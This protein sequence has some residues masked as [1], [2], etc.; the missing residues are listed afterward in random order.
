MPK[1]FNL[2]GRDPILSD[3]R[4]PLGGSQKQSLE[5]KLVYEKYKLYCESRCDV[6]SVILE[7]AQKCIQ[8][9]KNKSRQLKGESNL[10]FK[11]INHFISYHVSEYVIADQ[12]SSG[13]KTQKYRSQIARSLIVEGWIQEALKFVEKAKLTA[14]ENLELMF[15]YEMEILNYDRELNNQERYR[16]FTALLAKMLR[17]IEQQD[18]EE[19]EGEAPKKPLEI[20]GFLIG[21]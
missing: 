1:Y 6:D 17:V 16:R 5:Q 2:I 10:M 4:D 15:Q 8:Q 19:Q 21:P 12:E 20:T 14:N 18:L 11:R 13:K 7:L 9:Y 3:L